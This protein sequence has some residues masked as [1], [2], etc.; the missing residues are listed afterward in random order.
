MGMYF[1]AKVLGKYCKGTLPSPEGVTKEDVDRMYNKLYSVEELEKKKV[2]TP[3]KN[4]IDSYFNK[5]LSKYVSLVTPNC[6]Q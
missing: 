1:D 3:S 4:T 2:E 6:W 5:I